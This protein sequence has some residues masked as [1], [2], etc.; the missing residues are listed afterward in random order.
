MTEKALYSFISNKL[1]KGIT[2]ESKAANK[3]FEMEVKK[4]MIIDKAGIKKDNGN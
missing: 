4:R 3:E 1:L 2:K